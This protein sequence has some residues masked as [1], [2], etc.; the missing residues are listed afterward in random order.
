MAK[1]KAI[2]KKTAAKKPAKSLARTHHEKDYINLNDQVWPLERD[3]L[4]RPDRYR[5]VRKLIKPEGCVFCEAAKRA[6]AL[7]TFVFIKANI[8][9]SCSINF[10]TTRDMF[11]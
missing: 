9:W 6:L 11:W 2:K 5:Y 1:K 7:R 3:V 10:P 4:F 8:P